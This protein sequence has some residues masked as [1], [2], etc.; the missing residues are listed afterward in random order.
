MPETRTEPR[1]LDHDQQR[2]WRALALG[3]EPPESDVMKRPPY[4]ATESVFGRGMPTFIIVFGVVLMAVGGFTG[5]SW[6]EKKF[7][8]TPAREGE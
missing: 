7:A 3:I 8:R 1:W 6:V 5:A 2:S 4:S